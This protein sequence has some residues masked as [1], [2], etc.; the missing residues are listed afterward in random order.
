[1]MK[2]VQTSLNKTPKKRH[3]KKGTKREDPSVNQKSKTKSESLKD[4]RTNHFSKPPLVVRIISK[5]ERDEKLERV[6]I[7]REF[8]LAMTM[9]LKIEAA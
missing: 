5:K 7:L 3:E 9:H 6:V 2:H 8:S 1:M 4:K